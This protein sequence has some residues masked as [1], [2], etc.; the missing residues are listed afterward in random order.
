MNRFKNS[1]LQPLHANIAQSYAA[2]SHHVNSKRLAQIR[3]SGLPILVLTGT[4]DNFVRPSG[5]YHL[6][7]ELQCK[8]VVFE[9]SG[10]ALPGEQTETYCRFIEEIVIKGKDGEFLLNKL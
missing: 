6:Q 2:L 10:H 3:D 9:G 8:L 1:P 5:S 4:V 7:K